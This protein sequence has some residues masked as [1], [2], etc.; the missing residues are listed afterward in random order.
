MKKII[1]DRKNWIFDLFLHFLMLLTLCMS[2]AVVHAQD[3]QR[4]G[5]NYNHTSTGFPLTGVHVSVDCETC[6]T[7][8]IFK[9]TPT[10]CDGCHTAGQR[11][12]APGKSAKHIVTNRP[13]EVCHTNAVTFLGARFDH[14]GVLPGSCLSCHNSSMAAGKPA[15]HVSTT[16]NCDSCHRTSAW[17]PA[18]FN[19]QGMTADCSTCHISGQNPFFK[20]VITTSVTGTNGHTAVNPP[21]CRSCHTNY[22]SFLNAMY[23]HAGASPLCASCHVLKPAGHVTTSAD[24]GDCHKTKITW[25]GAVNHTPTANCWTCHST[26]GHPGDKGAVSGQSCASS[27]CHQPGGPFGTAYIRW[28]N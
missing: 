18:S 16:R 20:G 2:A 7:G 5:G 3:K 6:H 1:V 19:H 9:G 12:V 8:G 23:D 15:Q 14:M 11:V 22:G 25:L 21:L 27:G 17:F 24:C 26:R 4:A 28:T 10:T 13:C